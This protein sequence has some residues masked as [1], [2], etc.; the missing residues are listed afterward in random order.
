MKKDY[1]YLNQINF[2]YDL[3]KIPESKLQNVADEVRKELIEAV[4]VTG[5][6]LG[7]SL[8][9]VELTVALHYIFDTPKDKLIWDVGH[10]CYPHK[11]LTGRKDRI[12]TLRQGSGL[13]GFTKRLESEY[14]PFG[15]AHSST[16][17]SS[18]LGIAEANKLSNKSDN[19]VAVIGDGAISAGMAYEAMNNAG[20]S[21]TKMIVILND[22]DMSI[23]RPVGAMGTYLAKI[24]SGKIYF[25][26]RET[27]KLITSAFSKRFSA[28]AGKAEDLL[29]SAVTGG[30]L[31]SSLGFYYIG[32]IDGHDLN[33]LLPILKNA[34]DTK[35]NGPILIHI[36]T[37]KGK[38]YSYAEK[39]KDNYHGV[40]KFNVKTGE[41]LKSKVSI[42]SYTKVFANT[43]IQHAKK[44]SK[45]V[46]ITAAMPD[47]TGIDLFK[48]E[49]PDRAFD[50]GIAEQHAVTF[51]A[52]LATENYKPYAAIYST[53]LQRAYDQVVH[54]VAIQSLPVRFAIDRAGLVGADGPTHAGSFDTTFLTTLPNFVVMAASDEAELVR[55]INT[56]TDI[57]DKPCAF[58]YPRGTGVGVNLP[59]ITDKIEVG[60]SRIIREGKKLALL[61]FGAR[62][63]ETLKATENLKKKGVDIT[64][65][66]A[67]FA[68]PLDE[69]LIW[70]LATT[71][72]AI[73]TIEEGSI[74]GFG[75]HVVDFL[76]KKGLIDTNL[77]F[78]SMTLPDLFIDQDTPDNMYK[79]ANLDANSIENNVLDLLNSNI[80][81]QKQK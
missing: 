56:S 23:A 46:A 27:I 30:T 51:A 29:R 13:S 17:I 44:D 35:H 38:G 18:A 72:E 76:S 62:L 26:L 66:D 53:F 12:R 59:D 70:Q 63:N 48:K 73:M 7:A 6:H 8:G 36:K 32:P 68:K 77:K 2:P 19:V 16:S 75:S 14:D 41:Q 64:V 55:M 37:K 81:L 11:I 21:K 50:V 54:D 57:N 20:A 22:N 1:E 74:G 79:I 33:S 67:R 42:P 47:G 39:A 28:K 58:R 34:R 60:K 45:I 9:V 52:G 5:G 40:S 24:F 43:L 69:N 65:I 4:S 3:K 10:Q 71:H 78:R 31:F 80:I 15:A 61:S 49:F 25:S